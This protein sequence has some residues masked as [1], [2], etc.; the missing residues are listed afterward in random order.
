MG[1]KSLIFGSIK[2]LCYAG[3]RYI[4]DAPV[5]R[6][7][8][9][10]LS[11]ILLGNWWA[12]FAQWISLAFKD[13]VT[14]IMFML[15][16]P[17]FELLLSG[18]FCAS[19]ME[20]GDIANTFCPAGGMKGWGFWPGYPF[21]QMM[22]VG[23]IQEYPEYV[24]NFR[25]VNMTTY[26]YDIPHDAV[27]NPA[28]SIC[29]TA[30]ESTL[31]V[32]TGKGIGAAAVGLIISNLIVRLICLWLLFCMSTGSSGFVS[33]KISRI[34]GCCMGFCGICHMKGFSVPHD[35]LTRTKIQKQATNTCLFAPVGQAVKVKVAP[36]TASDQQEVTPGDP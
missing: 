10:A 15:M 5:I 34:T 28:T 19:V 9:Y 35:E 16:M 2:F 18:Q 22:W 1:T 33:D 31:F 26:W 4:L 25:P 3:V 7:S 20:A 21:F 6:F 13:Q 11:W 23:S 36:S 8:T 27:K 12:G 14:G 24:S 30:Y 17:I 29:G 32:G